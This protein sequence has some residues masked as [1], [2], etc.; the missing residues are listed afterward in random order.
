VLDCTVFVD[1]ENNRQRHAIPGTAFF[2]LRIGDA[3]G[4]DDFRLR[5]G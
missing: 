4:R 2:E 1:D 3:E 5:V